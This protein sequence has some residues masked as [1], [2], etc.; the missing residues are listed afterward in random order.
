MIL[1]LV[2]SAV[3]CSPELFLIF[4]MSVERKKKSKKSARERR[5]IFALSPTEFFSKIDLKRRKKKK[6]NR[7]HLE[8]EKHT[9]PQSATPAET[10]SGPVAPPA[11]ARARSAL[12]SPSLFLLCV[13]VSSFF[14]E[15]CVSVLCAIFFFM[16]RRRSE[17]KNFDFFFFGILIFCVHQT[18]QTSQP[19]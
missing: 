7:V 16:K 10:P 4:R 8:T 1:H 2:F 13:C 18:P 9:H 6:M 11:S 17:K 15:R 19:R 14:R 5:E 12:S 3:S